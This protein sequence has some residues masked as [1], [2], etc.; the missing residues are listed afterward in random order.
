MELT[1]GQL[2]DRAWA[3]IRE[4]IALFIGLTIVYLIAVA[5]SNLVVFGGVVGALFHYGYLAC[6]L[7]LRDKK[8]GKSLG[9][10]DFFWPFMDFNRLIHIVL[11]TLIVLVSLFI[12]FCFLLIPGIYLMVCMSLA[13]SYFILRKQD[14]IEA[15]RN[16]FF[17]VKGNWWFVF[18]LVILMIL[19]NVAGALCLGVG[20]LIS[21][22]L[23]CLVAIEA[24]LALEKQK[25][26]L[27]T[28][29]LPTPQTVESTDTPSV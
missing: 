2:F 21:L 28:G 13:S 26:S 15:L 8:N 12:G 6:L 14:A 24:F 22:P 1:Y 18:G 27:P 5:A 10:E 25:S 4:D 20:V 19:L 3:S 9:F 17:L 23:S 11:L 16:S 7:K 29:P